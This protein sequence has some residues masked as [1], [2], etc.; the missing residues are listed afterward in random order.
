MSYLLILGQLDVQASNSQLFILC[1]VGGYS[2]KASGTMLA[3][4]QFVGTV[5]CS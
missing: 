2:A 3:F 5:V 4:W 1:R